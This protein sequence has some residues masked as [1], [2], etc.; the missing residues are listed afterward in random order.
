MF[1]TTLVRVF[2]SFIVLGL[3]VVQHSHSHTVIGEHNKEFGF[4][5]KTEPYL[6][7]TDEH[8]AAWNRVF[9]D[10]FPLNSR[11]SLSDRCM[12]SLGV[13]FA[14]E[15]VWRYS[16]MHVYM[17]GG[18]RP[19]IY[20]D[21]DLRRNHSAADFLNTDV[22]FWKHIFDDQIEQR[23]ELFLRVIKDSK[24]LEIA[25]PNNNGLHD[26]M[27]DHCAAREMY[28]YAAYLSACV[29][30]ESRLNELHGD[31]SSL[32]YASLFSEDAHEI[33]GFNLLEK[34]FRLLKDWI[35][36][37]ALWSAAKSSMEKNYLHASWVAAQCNQHGFV[38]WPGTT[39][40]SYTSTEEKL[41]WN[42]LSL[43]LGVS[44]L[45]DEK[46]FHRLLNHTYSTTMKIAM[47][48]GD[49]WAIRSGYLGASFI[50]EFSAEL[51][52]RYPLLMHRVIGEPWNTWGYGHLNSKDRARHRA[53]AYL[54][55]VEEAGEEFA[56][57]EYD[58]AE[59]RKEIRF[60]KRGGKLK[61]P[62]SRA[63]VEESMREW[64]KEV[65][66][67]TQGQG[68]EFAQKALK[69]IIKPPESSN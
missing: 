7:V 15:P 4:P 35:S 64:A 54:L 1:S 66:E 58:P 45:A 33:D 49:D 42:S 69:L 36:D 32:I 38:L 30:A 67:S 41:P 29:D 27:A 3:A 20:I 48:A 50:A 28:K 40:G 39:T 63:E 46:K 12:S 18:W 2:A 52:Q 37:P 56:Q 9:E 6:P 68:N 25:Y 26:E 34:S 17:G 21:L 23:Q 65:E 43:G 60:V 10:C 19:L 59:L 16:K 13:Y 62:P 22:P 57:S 53:K 51:M 47:K 24:C 31:G 44:F 5:P 14:N 55:L 8:R 61:A 11:S